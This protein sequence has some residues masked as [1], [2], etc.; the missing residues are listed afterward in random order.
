MSWQKHLQYCETHIVHQSNRHCMDLLSNDLSGMVSLSLCQHGGGTLQTLQDILS[1]VIRTDLHIVYGMPP[2]GRVAR[3]R[4]LVHDLFLPLP[5]TGPADFGTV[6]RRYILASLFNG[7]LDSED[8][9]HFCAWNC[10]RDSS[11]TEAKFVQYAVAALLPHKLGKLA[12]NRW[13]GHSSCVNWCGLLQSHHQLLTKVI[14]RFTGRAV[15]GPASVQSVAA[16]A[17][18]KDDGDSSSCGEAYHIGLQPPSQAN[19]SGASLESA[20]L[21]PGSE[22]DV[23]DDEPEPAVAMAVEV[24]A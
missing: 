24:R 23:E 8:V 20:D 5:P 6:R 11:H 3:R 22:A 16:T 17:G 21:R 2:Q 9:T 19:Q 4:K 14:S 13:T 12:R 15:A 10:C 1:D 7:D 18:L